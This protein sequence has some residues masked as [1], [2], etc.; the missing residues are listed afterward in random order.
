M[1]SSCQP[2]MVGP[3]T[4]RIRCTGI[5]GGEG[6]RANLLVSAKTLLAGA[7]ALLLSTEVGLAALEG[8]ALAAQFRLALLQGGWAG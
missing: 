3:V 4:R 6:R 2:T 8:G 5:Q 7:K 1:R